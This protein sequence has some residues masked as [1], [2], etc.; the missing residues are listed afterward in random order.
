M[1][2]D[3]TYASDSDSASAAAA[4]VPV[5]AAPD[6]VQPPPS[7]RMFDAEE[8]DVDY[9]EV[10]GPCFALPYLNKL[11][12]GI[13]TAAR[14]LNDMLL[15]AQG[16]GYVYMPKHFKDAI[17]RQLSLHFQYLLEAHDDEH[18]LLKWLR[19]RVTGMVWLCL[20]AAGVWRT[21]WTCSTGALEA[22][23]A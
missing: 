10:N 4:V 22:Q 12:F 19:R 1:K 2:I 11:T 14:N 15:V 18:A 8:L 20:M 21:T 3:L 17:I 7:Y 9:F 23:S 13:G 6:S 16:P 5:A